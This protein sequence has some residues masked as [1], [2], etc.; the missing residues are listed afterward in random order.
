LNPRPV[1]CKSNVLP[2][3]PLRHQ[4]AFMSKYLTFPMPHKIFNRGGTHSK[5]SYNNDDQHSLSMCFCLKWKNEIFNLST[6]CDECTPW[7]LPVLTIFTVKIRAMTV[8]TMPRW[9]A[10]TSSGM[11][12][13]HFCGNA[14]PTSDQN[15]D[16]RGL[17]L[18]G[19][20]VI[21]V[22]LWFQANTRT[23]GYMIPAMWS[24]FLWDS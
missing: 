16:I 24:H 8:L 10:V 7:T 2:T 13:T 12:S 21:F 23:P 22:W 20:Q 11:A 19:Y 18:Q 9:H 5:V 15:P 14:T 6:Y 17:Q 3:V 1:N 4:S